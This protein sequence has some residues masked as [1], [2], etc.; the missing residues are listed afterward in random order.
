[1]QEIQFEIERVSELRAEL[2]RRLSDEYDG[3]TAAELKELDARLA[4][5][6]DQHRA[7]RAQLRFGD[8]ERIIARA[9]AEERLERAA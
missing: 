1:M 4:E 9:R 3:E 5:L 8:R 6:W 7:V 2:W